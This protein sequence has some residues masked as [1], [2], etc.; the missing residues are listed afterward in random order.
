MTGWTFIAKA[1]TAMARIARTTTISINV[2]PRC[3]LIGDY[4]N[5]KIGPGIVASSAVAKFF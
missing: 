5:E 1:V 2:I 3:P 4:L